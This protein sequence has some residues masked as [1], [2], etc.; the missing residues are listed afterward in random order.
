[1]THA[2]VDLLRQLLCLDPRKRITAVEALDHLWFWTAP[3][4]EEPKKLV[5]NSI[6]LTGEYKL[7]K[8]VV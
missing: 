6:S 4:P 8:L 5:G 2:A 3:L 7:M 1:M